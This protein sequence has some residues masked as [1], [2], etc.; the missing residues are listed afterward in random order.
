MVNT[1]SPPL[2]FKY[3]DKIDD[4]VIHSECTD[5]AI[6]WDKIRILHIISGFLDDR[7]I[8]KLGL[9]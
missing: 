2:F 5:R 8:P 9:Y 6:R 1:Q 7:K 4:I 3:P